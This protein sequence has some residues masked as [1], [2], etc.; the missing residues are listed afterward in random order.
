MMF[1]PLVLLSACSAQLL[2]HLFPAVA[3]EDTAFS[4]LLSTTTES[5]KKNPTSVA[6]NSGGL[7]FEGEKT[8]SQNKQP[9]KPS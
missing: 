1:Q 9:V 8:N 5:S 6:L 4:S 2:M 7:I 3:I